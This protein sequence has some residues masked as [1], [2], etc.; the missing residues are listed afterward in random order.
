MSGF[1]RYDHSVLDVSSKLVGFFS[2]TFGELSQG[3]MFALAAWLDWRIADEQWTASRFGS[4]EEHDYEA[5][6]RE[7]ARAALR[8]FRANCGN[9]GIS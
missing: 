7:L 5:I 9:G 8:C 3:Q 4:G 6:V 2:G 1:E